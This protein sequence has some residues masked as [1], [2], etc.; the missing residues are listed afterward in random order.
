M[1]SRKKPLET[2][3]KTP[4]DL[5][6]ILRILPKHKRYSGLIQSKL[7]IAVLIERW[8]QEK[9]IQMLDD[10]NSILIQLS[11]SDRD[12]LKDR[13]LNQ[14]IEGLINEYLPKSN[15]QPSYTFEQKK[16]L[17]DY[18]LKLNLQDRKHISY[19]PFEEELL[20]KVKNMYADSNLW[21]VWPQKKLA[22]LVDIYRGDFPKV[23]QGDSTLFTQYL[24][25]LRK[26]C[27]EKSFTVELRSTK[28]PKDIIEKSGDFR[29]LDIFPEYERYDWLLESGL[30]FEDIIQEKRCLDL[31]LFILSKRTNSVG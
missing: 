2:Y 21:N 9:R 16:F 8:I 26:Y 4:H 25:I 31:F 23:F 17:F 11:I 20:S 29:A 19:T 24:I 12:L 6:L 10:L 1:T 3:I 7:S 15:D 27:K 22:A 14:Y 18:L 5:S 30:P 13:Y 28:N